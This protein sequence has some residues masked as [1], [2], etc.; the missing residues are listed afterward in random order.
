MMAFLRVTFCLVGI[1]PGGE[2]TDGYFAGGFCRVASIHD[3][4]MNYYVEL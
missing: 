4:R 2:N 3:Q 1:L